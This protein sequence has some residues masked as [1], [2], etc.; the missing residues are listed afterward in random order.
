M[1]SKTLF[2]HLN[3]FNFFDSAIHWWLPH[4]A[5]SFGLLELA[6]A[7]HISKSFLA[8]LFIELILDLVIFESL[9]G[10]GFQI[11]SKWLQGRLQI[12]AVLDFTT[13]IVIYLRI[14]ICK[15]I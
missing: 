3:F 6:I 5:G 2:L 1:I 11:I 12:V 13:G 14:V 9:I 7:L 8:S 4:N 15:Q 10:C